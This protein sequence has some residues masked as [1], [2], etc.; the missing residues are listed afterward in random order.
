MTFFLNRFMNF[1]V[2][3]FYFSIFLVHFTFIELFSCDSTTPWKRSCVVLS[4][5][6]IRS[7][8][9]DHVCICLFSIQASLK[10]NPAAMLPGAVPTLPGAIS[11]FPGMDPSSSSGVSSS[12]LSPSPVTTPV[13]AQTDSEGVTFDTPVQVTTLQSVQKVGLF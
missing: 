2:C 3:F 12:S 1:T 8:G 11:V 9:L 6:L 7:L 5:Y 4:E 10:I 13:G